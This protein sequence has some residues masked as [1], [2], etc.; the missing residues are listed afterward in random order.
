MDDSWQKLTEILSDEHKEDLAKML[1][2]AIHS[3][4]WNM[5]E[6]EVNNHTMHRIYITRGISQRK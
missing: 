6:I 2:E 3:D 5:V 1:L 4:Q